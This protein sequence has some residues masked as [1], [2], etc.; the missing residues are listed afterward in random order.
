MSRALPAVGRTL[1]GVGM[2]GLALPWLLAPVMSDERYH[3]IA[4]PHRFHDNVFAVLPWTVHDMAWRMAA[5]RIA[6]VGV[7]I[8][9][10]VYLAG[11]EL[12]VATGLP[13][14]VVHGLVKLAVSVAVVGSFALLWRLLRGPSGGSVGLAA[15]TAAAIFAVG[16][17][18]G[19]TATDPAQ[20]GWT[21]FVVLCQG[22]IVLMF[23]LGALLLWLDGRWAG[24]SGPARV[25][26]VA[27]VA[28][29]AVVTVLSYELHWAA[30]PFAAVLV[31]L[32]GRRRS[33]LILGGTLLVAGAVA[34]GVVRAQIAAHLTDVYVGLALDIRG[35]VLKTWVWQLVN[36]VPVTGIPI[37]RDQLGAGV[38]APHPFGAWG[39]LWG[40]VLA[41]GWVLASTAS[42]AGSVL[43]SEDRPQAPDGTDRRP[44]VALAVALAV[45]AASAAAVLSVSTQAHQLVDGLG[46]AYRGTP[47]IWACFVGIVVVALAAWPARGGR[48]G[49][50]PAAPALAARTWRIAVPALAALLAGVFVL[51]SS[52]AAIRTLRADDTYALWERAQA[53]VIIGSPG[54]AALAE[55]CELQQQAKAWQGDSRYR[56]GYLREYT[57]AFD[58]LWGRP[59]C[60]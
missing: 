4:A 55:R 6:P 38:P 46:E 12:A 57:T 59:W 14:F 21:T 3:Y 24:G 11:M 1:V 13:L 50:G 28:L 45:S 29:A 40:V 25:V 9:H 36:A 54:P 51:P 47:W 44:L 39:W 43:P 32:A 5:G 18:A 22:G 19:I 41:V 31:V 58:Y 35:P 34:I 52:V 20:N 26:S 23:G 17:L 53:Q 60:P 15:R 2:G 16:Y 48:A 33:S 37:T 10:V 7:A 30:L 42:G 56:A 8:Q 49:G 27:V